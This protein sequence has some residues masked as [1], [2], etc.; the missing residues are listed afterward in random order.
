MQEAKY[1]KKLEEEKVQCLLCLKECVIGDGKR[2]FCRA[3]ENKGGKLYSRIFAQA[4]SVAM[5]PI[6]KKPLY[7]FYPGTMILSLGTNGCNFACPFCQNWEISQTEVATRTI[8]PEEAVATAKDRGSIGIAYTYSEPLIWYEYV[9]ETAR[10]AHER[11]LKNVLVTNG[12][13][14]EEPLRELLPYID[15]LNIDV[16]AMKDSFYKGMCKAELGPVLRT[17]E[18]AN[19]KA[20]VEITNLIIPTI[21]NGEDDFRKLIDW[22]A[23]SLGVDTPLHFSRYFPHYKMKIEP[24]P[25]S[26]LEKA[27]NMAREKLRYVYLGNVGGEEANSTRCY[28]CGKSVILRAGYGVAA[29]ELEDGK[30]RYCQAQI[31]VIM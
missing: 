19:K 28:R 2:G 21:N 27:G 14:N 24:T 23:N 1:Y 6:E 13:I 31:N 26:T 17:A 22:V 20:L 11:G 3:R 16:K 18:I 7:H 10:L 30:C 29:M 9:L 5:D 4:T 15:A 8:T 12:F 25:I